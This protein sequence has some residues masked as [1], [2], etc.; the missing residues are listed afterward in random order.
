MLP[1]YITFGFYLVM[2]V[3]IGVVFMRRTSGNL[4]EFL[5]GGRGI[6]RWVTAMSAQA[7]DMSGWLLMGLP[8]AIYMIQSRSGWGDIWCALGLALGTFLNWTLV[9]PRLRIYSERTGSLTVTAYI[10]NRFRDDSGML[11]ITSALATLLFFTVYSASG[12]VAAGKLFESMFGIDY[13]VAVIIGALVI[14]AYV[15]MGGYPAVCWTDLV[16]GILMFFALIAVPVYAYFTNPQIDFGAALRARDIV[17]FP[18]GV[19]AAALM[20]IVSAFVW[21]L[22]YFG[23]PHILTR[24]MSIRS[25]RDLPRTTLIAMIWVV[26]SLTAAVVIGLVAI[27][28]WDGDRIL[29]AKEAE[30][31][32]IYMV[33]DFFNPWIGGVLMAAILAAIMSTI[34]SQLLVSSSTLTEDIFKKMVKKP[35]S[36]RQLVRLSRFFVLAI[37]ALALALALADLETIFSLV[38]FAWGGFGAA[39]GPVIL[40]SLYFR[41]MSRQAAFAGMVT[42]MAVMLGWY[43]AGYSKYMYEIL[44][45]FAAGLLAIWIVGRIRP[46]RDPAVSAEFDAMLAELH[47]E[48]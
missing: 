7:S 44:P 32:F 23:Q 13:A 34:D 31:V 47:S 18:D 43:F 36:D 9:A 22:G 4:D 17:C 27:P 8:G 5:L 20:A 46:Q 35:L 15:F 6:G 11:R 2:M 41:G 19:T 38:K 10:A 39:F 24:F 40:C 12:L 3:V 29:G 37:T 30:R 28:L 26:I 16:Q 33:R 48:K 45:G 14:L 1:T 42:G 21:G 25:F